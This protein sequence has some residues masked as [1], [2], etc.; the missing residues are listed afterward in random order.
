MNM[1]ASRLMNTFW[2]RMEIWIESCFNL[3][4]KFLCLK[5]QV[6]HQ[7]DFPFGSFPSPLN[8]TE[9]K[10]LLSRYFVRSKN[11]KFVTTQREMK[12]LIVIRCCV[13][14]LKSPWN[15]DRLRS[16]KKKRCFNFPLYPFSL[17]KCN[18]QN[19]F[20]F[21]E[22]FFCFIY[23][24][25]FQLQTLP[26]L[27]DSIIE[28][29]S[30]KSETNLVKFP[31]TYKTITKHGKITAQIWGKLISNLRNSKPFWEEM[32]QM[33]F[34]IRCFCT[35]WLNYL[36]SLRD[37]HFPDFALFLFSRFIVYHLSF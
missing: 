34:Y 24:G 12:P 23:F 6:S 1:M 26:S 5:H 20:S 28:S 3:H 17:Q 21:F 31:L 35:I 16:I 14:Y 37:L 2:K 32:K 30:L 15:S 27:I 22:I 4:T 25:S 8:K 10:A 9:S 29:C 18:K 7:N 19:F 11:R 33:V 36:L 13:Q